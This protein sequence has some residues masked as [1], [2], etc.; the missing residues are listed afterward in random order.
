M[1]MKEFSRRVEDESENKE[2]AEKK[3]NHYVEN[4]FF[5]KFGWNSRKENGHEDSTWKNGPNFYEG[6]NFRSAG[7]F[8]DDEGVFIGP[9]NIIN[10]SNQSKSEKKR[11]K[12]AQFTP[13]DGPEK[14]LP[15]REIRIGFHKSRMPDFVDSIHPKCSF[16][17]NRR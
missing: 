13:A 12:L 11:Q 1:R 4:F 2:K 5:S 8:G 10:K 7:G 14:A 6:E 9:K 15:S 3:K 16:M 17:Y